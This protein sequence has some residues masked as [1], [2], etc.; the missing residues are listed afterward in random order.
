[1]N[2]ESCNNVDKLQYK[3]DPITLDQHFSLFTRSLNQ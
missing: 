2:N 3:K 1:M